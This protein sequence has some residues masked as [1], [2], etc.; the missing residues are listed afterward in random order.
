VIKGVS[1]PC[2]ALYVSHC[3]QERQTNLLLHAFQYFMPALACFGSAS[4]S[5]PQY[6]EPVLA[7]FGSASI[8][9]PQYC[10]PAL[11][12][13]DSASISTPHYCEP[14][15]ACYDSASISSPQGPRAITS[16]TALTSMP[17]TAR[18]RVTTSTW[19]VRTGILSCKAQ[20][21]SKCLPH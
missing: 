18:S 15:L 16:A 13:F 4:I 7:C 11:A 8:N 2:K 9:T 20:Y 19:P 10:Q 6:C 14:V 5:T 12:C 21:V 17:G 3:L 1:P